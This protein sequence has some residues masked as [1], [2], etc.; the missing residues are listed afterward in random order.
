[1]F[2]KVYFHHLWVNYVFWQNQI[3]FHWLR[4]IGACHWHPWVPWALVW[5]ILE[6]NQWLVWWFQRFIPSN[7]SLNRWDRWHVITQL[8][9]YTTYI[10]VVGFK[11]F[12]FF[13]PIWGNG[14]VWKESPFPNHP[15]VTTSGGNS[16]NFWCSPRKLGKWSNLTH[17]FQMGWN[18]QLGEIAVDVS[19]MLYDLISRCLS[20][21]IQ[22]FFFLKYL[23]V[24][25][26]AYPNIDLIVFPIDLLLCINGCNIVI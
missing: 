2:V 22:M 25:P 19:D 14:H 15:K 11:Y 20:D 24:Y 6:N 10:L 17:I 7:G 16:N 3:L 21:D 1:M 4:F 26:Q 9:I 18:H 5:K 8:A 23:I 13:I 12:W